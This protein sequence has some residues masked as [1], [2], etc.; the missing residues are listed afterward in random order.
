MLVGTTEVGE[1]EG[2]EVLVFRVEDVEREVRG[3]RGICMGPGND[4]RLK[5]RP[6]L[7]VVLLSWC[8]GLHHASHTDLLPANK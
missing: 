4:V 5:I 7:W 2:A 8:S 1:G 3:D 6:R